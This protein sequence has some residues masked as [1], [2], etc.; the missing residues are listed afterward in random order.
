MMNIIELQELSFK[1]VK[2]YFLENPQ[3]VNSD[4]DGEGGRILDYAGWWS[5]YELAYF[6]IE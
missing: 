5:S 2:K 3:E 1:E 6:L 4:I